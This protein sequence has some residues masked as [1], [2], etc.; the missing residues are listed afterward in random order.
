MANWGSP[1]WEPNTVILRFAELPA[2]RVLEG[3]GG[4]LSSINA[5]RLCSK[6]IKRQ[7]AMPSPA[8]SLLPGAPVAA[9]LAREAL[10]GRRVG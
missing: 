2:Y 8:P 3:A 4:L 9:G 5:R 10:G 7:A 6:Q 1:L